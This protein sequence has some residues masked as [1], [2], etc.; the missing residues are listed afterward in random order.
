MSIPFGY[1]VMDKFSHDVA[2]IAGPFPTEREAL[3]TAQNLTI[4]GDCAIIK[5]SYHVVVPLITPYQPP[6]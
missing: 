4:A 6:S 3:A 2:S 5:V 1:H